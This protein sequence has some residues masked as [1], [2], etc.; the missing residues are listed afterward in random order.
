MSKLS[1][2]FIGVIVAGLAFVASVH[3][4]RAYEQYAATQEKEDAFATRTFHHVPIDYTPQE[5]D[6][7]VIKKLPDPSEKKEFFLED[8]PLIPS[9]EKEQAR[10]TVASILSDYRQDPGLQALYNDLQKTTGRKIDLADLSGENLA[11]LLK[12]YPQAQ[13]VIARHAK[14]P[15]LA[16][17]LQEIFSNPQFVRSVTVL[18]GKGSSDK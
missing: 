5:P 16:K 1:R 13:E 8:T 11:A 2:F 15:A 9:A 17:T 14:D 12:Q 3:L 10:Q 4:Y 18:Q 7:P 6:F